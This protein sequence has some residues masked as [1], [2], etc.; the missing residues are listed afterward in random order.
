MDR[1]AAS[2]AH[3]AERS[4]RASKYRG[5]AVN[6]KKSAFAAWNHSYAMS[7]PPARRI[8]AAS[9]TGRSGPRPYSS[10]RTVR[11]SPSA[12]DAAAKP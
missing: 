9:T 10:P 3:Q 12:S 7:M 1:A 6:A 5:T 11:P 2:T 8:I 4:R